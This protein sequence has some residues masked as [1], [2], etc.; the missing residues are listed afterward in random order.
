MWF[1]CYS[2]ISNS[3][4]KFDIFGDNSNI[5]SIKLC[6]LKILGYFV[7]TTKIITYEKSTT[8]PLSLLF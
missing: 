6:L 1:I 5:R 4:Y 2:I 7:E 8:K 3:A